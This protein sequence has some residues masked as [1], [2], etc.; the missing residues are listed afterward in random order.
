M[1]LVE[2]DR[3]YRILA[4][5]IV[6]IAFTTLQAHIHGAPTREDAISS[7]RPVNATA[8]V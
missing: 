1:P 3:S 4:T 5:T 6:D 7:V 2:C 8:A